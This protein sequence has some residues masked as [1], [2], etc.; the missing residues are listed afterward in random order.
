MDRERMVGF[1]PKQVW[2]AVRDGT[3]AE[4]RAALRLR[5]LGPVGW[6]AGIDLAHLTDDRVALTPVVD[7][8]G[9]S[10]W[11]LVVGRWL[12]TGPVSVEDLSA[13]L[14]TEVHRYST[15]RGLEQHEWERAVTGTLVRSFAYSGRS[16]EVQRWVGDPDPAETAIGISDP[17]AD[18]LVGESDVLRIAE[19]WSVDPSGLD[20]GPATGPLEAAAP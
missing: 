13:S 18:I 12:W 1:G 16:A 19:A 4:V 20:G 8:V 10:R 14:G 15:H 17:D 6:R 2:L 3:A 11:L 5:N 7:G 9:G